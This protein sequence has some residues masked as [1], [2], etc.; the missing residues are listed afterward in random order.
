MFRSLSRARTRAR[1]FNFDTRFSTPRDE[2][3]SPFI[4]S[5]EKSV[6]GEAARGRLLFFEDRTSP[7]ADF[8][9]FSA[10]RSID[11]EKGRTSRVKDHERRH[12]GESESSI[13]EEE[14]RRRRW[15]RRRRRRQLR[16]PRSAPARPMPVCCLFLSIDLSFPIL[17]FGS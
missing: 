17:T 5:I 4:K 11:P 6:G 13:V 8:P 12:H 16:D 9:R 3:Y 7:S 10:D 2:N 1:A 14:E 15:R